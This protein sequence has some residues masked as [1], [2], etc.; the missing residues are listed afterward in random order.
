MS[1][2]YFYITFKRFSAFTYSLLYITSVISNYNKVREKRK[3]LTRKIYCTIN[4][5]RAS[6]IVNY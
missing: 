5:L 4:S 3:C 6:E 1:G 2:L